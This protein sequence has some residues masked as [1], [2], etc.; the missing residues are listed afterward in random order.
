M[1]TATNVE[2]REL[3]S[4][5]PNIEH[6]SEVSARRRSRW[7]LAL[8]PFATIVVALLVFPMVLIMRYALA[9]GN[10]VLARVLSRPDTVDV[11]VR[12]LA[13]STETTFL[14]GILAYAYCGMLVRLSG[15]R[16]GIALAVVAI[17]VLTSVLIRSYAWLIVLGPSGPIGAMTRLIAGPSAQPA[18]LYNRWGVLI[19]MVQVMLPFFIL[20]LYAVWSQV[21]NH[22][23]PAAR[24]LGANAA[25]A[26]LRVTLPL[27]I[28]GAAAGAVLVFIQ[29]IGFYITPAMLG[30]SG[31]TMMAQLISRYI[32]GSG[33]AGID[34][35][36]ASVLSFV[37]IAT[38]LVITVLFRL[39]YP[40]EGLFV[41]ELRDGTT[42]R[43]RRSVV[44]AV[45]RHDPPEWISSMLRRCVLLLARLPWKQLSVIV[46]VGVAL[47]LIA[48]LVIVIPVSFSG[49][50]FLQFPP[51]TYGTRWYQSI[52]ADE[53]WRQAAGN[54][55]FVGLVATA[56]SG[57]AGLPLALALTRASWSSRLKGGIMGLLALPALVPNVVLAVGIFVWFLELGLIRS[58]VALGAVHGLAAL[59]FVGFVLIST[60]KDFDIQIERAA[61][62]LG[63]TAIQAL[64]LVT[65]PVLR[66]GIL[67]AVFFAFLISLDE[68]LV[69]RAVTDVSSATLP[70][71][72]WSG[73]NEQISPGLAA[74]ST[75]SLLLTAASAL[76]LRALR[77]SSSRSKRRRAT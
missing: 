24:T 41:P 10:E 25:Q 8:I 36:A 69:A 28:P 40:I 15:R 32:A 17:P 27:T 22:L 30:G 45:T 58:R 74:V 68:L 47:Y 4:R 48:P 39:S 72:I 50:A 26:F 77:S 5:I 59:P 44:R 57:V 33:S 51:S 6:A 29:S 53:L 3:R 76:T 75:M 13:I 7:S 9:G 60:L 67:A 61:R 19:G 18:L 63:A 71:R 16:R 14:C 1:A 56:I 42:P 38:V 43:R 2:E 64:R 70:I 35:T 21:P 54:S 62:S 11:L 65:L 46:G 23:E 49:D 55:L 31:D 66:R 12:T 52:L 73:A 37:L 20:P 34:L